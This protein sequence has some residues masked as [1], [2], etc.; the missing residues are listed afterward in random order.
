M[1]TIKLKHYFKGAGSKKLSSVDAEPRRSNQHEIGTTALMRDQFLGCEDRKKFIVTYIWLGEEQDA[2]S[3]IGNARHYD[4]RRVNPDRSAEWRLYY[5]SNAVTKAMS[6]GDALFLAL[7][8]SGYLLFIVTPAGSSSEAQLSKIFDLE[9]PE[10][11]FSSRGRFTD[12]TE[13]D[14]VT[15]YILDEIGVEY[16]VP[17]A[18]KIDE[19][20]NEFG[21]EFPKSKK[22]S[23][24]ARDS[25][26]GIDAEDDPDA[27]LIN[28]L[29]FEENLFKRLEAKIIGEKV[30]YGFMIGDEPDVDGFIK[31]SLSVQNRRKSRMGHSLQNHLEEIFIIHKLRFDKEKITENRQK[32][33]F[34]FPSIEEYF[35][36]P[37]DGSGNLL[38][39]AAK[40]SCKDRWRQV[41]PEAERI[42][43]KHLLT[44]EPGITNNQTDQMKNSSLQ[45]VVP[46]EI[47]ASYKQEQQSWLLTLSDFI[48]E[49]KLRFHNDN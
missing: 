15:R 32:P 48:K 14:F 16:E 28:W 20:I 10:G 46:R 39:L 49:V 1:E 2:I 47:Q 7:H 3:I 31:Y 33:D 40:S 9:P 44:L 26:L 45:L 37:S 23:E 19:L 29:S 5:E 35:K 13:L 21:V 4:T 36:A 27:A 18:D 38:M 8:E 22:M 43:L 42:H 30:K 25:L 17:N 24:L 6:E 12:E 11:A 41:L 34:I